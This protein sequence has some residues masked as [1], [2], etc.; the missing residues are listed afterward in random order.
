MNRSLQLLG[1]AKKAGFLAV[2]AES[3]SAAARLGKAAAVISACDA[4]EGSIRRARADSIDCGAEFIVVPFTKFE[5]GNV[6]GRG[7]PG[8]L[9]ITDAGL[10]SAFLGKLAESDPERYSQAAEKLAKTAEQLKK[11]KAAGVRKTGKG[12]TAI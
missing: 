11:R 1:M 10:A 3:A 8:T 4:S 7:S 6:T 2:G 9:A 12:R 5:L